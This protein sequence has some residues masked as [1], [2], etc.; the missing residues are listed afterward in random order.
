MRQTRLSLR[1]EPTQKRVLVPAMPFEGNAPIQLL[2]LIGS[3][4]VAA[5]ADYTGYI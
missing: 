4:S 1:A 2:E 3:V 5:P